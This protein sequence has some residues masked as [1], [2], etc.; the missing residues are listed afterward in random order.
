MY[1]CLNKLYMSILCGEFKW[2]YNPRWSYYHSIA[3]E[4]HSMSKIFK[5][6]QLILMDDIFQRSY[7]VAILIMFSNASDENYQWLLEYKN[8]MDYDFRE[9]F[10]SN[11]FHGVQYTNGTRQR[12]LIDRSQLLTT[13]F[14]EFACVNSKLHFNGIE[15]EFKGEMATGSGVFREWIFLV[16]QALFDPDNSLFLACPSDR[17]RFFPNP[18]T[19]DMRQL[20]YFTFSGRMVALALKYKVQVGIAFDSVFFK[21]LSGEVISWEDI[22]YA[23]PFLYNSCKKILEMDADFVD[24]DVMALTFVTEIEEFVGNKK[25]VEL[26]RGGSS[27]AVNSK[28]REEYIKLLIHH[29]YVKP[30]S[31][32][33]AFFARG[34]GEILREEPLQRIFFRCLELKDLDLMLHGNDQ[35]ISV[36]EW[37]V[38]TDYSGYEESDEQ[39]CWFW[40]D[41]LLYHLSCTS[42]R[43]R[44]LAITCLHPIHAS[45]SWFFRNTHL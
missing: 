30:I 8:S 38:H 33:V 24:S 43:H 6:K 21:Q 15:V 41:F 45:M 2:N 44:S 19:M 31:E 29:S 20:D 42:T 18:V 34:F 37:R 12:I 26:C 22:C 39:I 9:S 25:I 36:K 4:V 32:K 27:I 40:K 17:R 28:N 14:D 13:S 7:M 16:C 3:K 11:M 10:V 5:E 1:D 35:A 23:D